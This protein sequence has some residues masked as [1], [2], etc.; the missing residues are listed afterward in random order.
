MPDCVLA[1]ADILILYLRFVFAGAAGEVPSMD[2]DRIPLEVV[3]WIVV[4]VP[5]ADA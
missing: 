3:R 5:A 1:M 4:R 2:A